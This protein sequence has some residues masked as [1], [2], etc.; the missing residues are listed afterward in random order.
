MKN[1]RSNLPEDTREKLKKL[2]CLFLNFVLFYALYRIIIEFSERLRM[3]VIYYVGA[4]VYAGIAVVTFIWFFVLNGF[5]FDKE[6]RTIDELPEKW[7]SDKKM[8]F[9]GKQS[10]NKAKARRLM[11]ILLP[12]VIVLLVD[13]IG[14]MFIK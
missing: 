3:P 13:Y 6:E 4:G 5:T 7:T 10:E 1:N 8:E 12:I 9:L 11:Y 2:G 14:L